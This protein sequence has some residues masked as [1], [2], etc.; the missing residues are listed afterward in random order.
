[1]N[2]S[3]R[4][5]CIG[6]LLQV[7]KQIPEQHRPPSV[8]IAEHGPVTLANATDDYSYASAVANAW[9]LNDHGVQKRD[10]QE[11]VRF[12]TVHSGIHWAWGLPPRG[13]FSNTGRHPI[14]LAGFAPIAGTDLIA[15]HYIW[16]GLWGRGS[17][18]RY[19]PLAN[20]LECTANIWLS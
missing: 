12:M 19:D 3:H 8:W 9:L 6:E 18:Y 4:Q 16:G 13:I 5:A 1:M 7:W 10:P 15:L 11:Y 17:H 14:A 20:A 2:D